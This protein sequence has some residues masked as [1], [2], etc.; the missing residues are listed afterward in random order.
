MVDGASPFRIWRSIYLPLGMPAVATA[1]ILMGVDTWNQYL[2]PVLVAHSDRTHLISVVVGAFF[3]QDSIRWDNAMAASVL[4]MI[5]ML[6]LYLAFQRWFVS[7]FV[8]SAVK[9]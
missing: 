7:A 2:G 3:G 6:L 4:M 5:P 1:S 8:G 9:G